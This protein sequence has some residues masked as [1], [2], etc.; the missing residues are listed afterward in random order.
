MYLI[1]LMYRRPPG[2][3]RTDPLFPS[4]TLSRSQKSPADAGLCRA[5]PAGS[6]Q[7]GIK[8]HQRCR[9]GAR[10]ADL[11]RGFRQ[12]FGEVETRGRQLRLVE[13]AL[14]RAFT[15][16]RNTC[17][18]CPQVRVDQMADDAQI[19]HG[20]GTEIRSEE[21]TSELQSLMRHS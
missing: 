6:E 20:G 10:R 4:P 12:Q 19:W 18:P 1:F 7:C 16:E 9:T 11:E 14:F 8:L 15:V 2:S 13:R 17:H 3:T 21:H 5:A